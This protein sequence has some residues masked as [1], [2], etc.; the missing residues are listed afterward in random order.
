VYKTKQCTAWPS[1]KHGRE[2]AYL[3]G[4]EDANV[5]DARALI[6]IDPYRDFKKQPYVSEKPL[7][8]TH[9]QDDV[10]VEVDATD[11]PKDVVEKSFTLL[12]DWQC[13]RCE[14]VGR[15]SF[16]SCKHAACKHIRPLKNRETGVTMPR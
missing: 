3:H 11:A 1:C 16:A 6:N 15:M 5:E 2:C 12:R 8:E 13:R 7:P 4:S 10:D 9:Q 14:E